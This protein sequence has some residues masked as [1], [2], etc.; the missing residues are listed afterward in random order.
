MPRLKEVRRSRINP[1]VAAASRI[2]E[3]QMKEL[4]VAISELDITENE[5]NEIEAKDRGRDRLQLEGKPLKSKLSLHLWSLLFSLPVW[6]IIAIGILAYLKTERFPTSLLSTAWIA[7]PYLL[8]VCF[9]DAMKYL[10]NMFRV[11]DVVT[12]I[13]R[14]RGAP[15]YWHL[16]CK[17]YHTE[18]RTRWVTKHHTTYDHNGRPQHST[19]TELEHYLETIVTHTGRHTLSIADCKDISQ[20]LTDSI[21]RYK[22]VCVDFSYEIELSDDQSREIYSLQ[23]KEFIEKNRWRDKEFDYWEDACMDGYKKRV[24]SVVDI[25]S[26]PPQLSVGAFLITT[27]IGGAWIYQLWFSSITT[28]GNYHYHRQVKLAEN[29]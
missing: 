14:V 13:N 22:I 16:N 26:K 19:T 18:W 5:L 17:C 11:E 27:L 8:Q 25:K 9:S 12:H 4:E 20:D 15:V 2:S 1:T 23:R 21:Y 7:I 29:D 3:L 10:W 24:L 28:K 6:G